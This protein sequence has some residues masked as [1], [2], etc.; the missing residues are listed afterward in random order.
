VRKEKSELER[1]NER[2][3]KG[4]LKETMQSNLVATETDT[5]KKVDQLEKVIK[6]AQAAEDKVT[7]DKVA[8]EAKKDSDHKVPDLEFEQAFEGTWSQLE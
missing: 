4:A 8:K 7:A 1:K 5:K 3:S 2:K 6:E